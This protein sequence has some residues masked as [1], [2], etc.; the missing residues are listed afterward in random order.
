MYRISVPCCKKEKFIY[1]SEKNPIASENI[2]IELGSIPIASG[3]I[4]I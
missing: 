2:S 1:S 3:N 4:P